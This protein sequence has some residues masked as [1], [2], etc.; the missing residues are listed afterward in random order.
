MTS[1]E[2]CFRSEDL[3]AGRRVPEAAPSLGKEVRAAASR[4][5]ILLGVHG[6]LLRRLWGWAAALRPSSQVEKWGGSLSLSPPA[7]IKL[8]QRPWAGP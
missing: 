6:S 3:P 4:R 8:H 1:R 7:V 2:S 5:R